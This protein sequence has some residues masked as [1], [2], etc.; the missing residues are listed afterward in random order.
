[1]SA[2]PRRFRVFDQVTRTAVTETAAQLGLKPAA[3]LAIAE[4][5]SGGTAYAIISGKREP[6][7][8]FEGHYFDRRLA[9]AKRSKAREAGLASPDAG[10]IANPAS[11]T[12]RWALLREAASIDHVAAYESV[13]WGV[14]QVMG[15][16]WLW[17]GYPS[18]DALVD[19]ARSGVDGQIRLMARYIEKA[20]LI[21]IIRASDWT[22][23]ARAYNG[24]SFAQSGYDK[25]IAKAYDRY[26][27]DA[28]AQTS[29]RD[30]GGT[31]PTAAD[32]ADIQ[33]MLSAA[34][35]PLKV[36]GIA[37]AATNKAVRRFQSDAGLMVDGI[38]GP[39]TVAALRSALPLGTGGTSLWYC[40]L[41]VV[42]SVFGR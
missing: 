22:A 12:G 32:I 28:G 30:K 37:G 26:L 27:N 10:A 15:A 21:D 42:R 20:G 23:F 40:M 35:Y 16:H 19:E 5:E 11:Q 9:G 3:L 29:V 8:R 14:G 34:G 38:A 31:S 18:V 2:S 25:K 33:R 17:L 41:K 6:L 39:K 24:P 36:D 7:I 4:V 1:M 13:S